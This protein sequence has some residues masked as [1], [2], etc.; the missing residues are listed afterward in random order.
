MTEFTATH[1]GWALCHDNQSVLHVVPVRT[2]NK[3]YTG[4]PIVEEFFSA[5]IAHKRI[6]EIARS[7]GVGEDD[8]S[9]IINI[10]FGL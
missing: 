9:E 8:L 1:D 2:G 6:V 10:N 3:L 4:Q 5:D 7:I